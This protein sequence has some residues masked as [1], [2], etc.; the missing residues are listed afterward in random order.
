MIADQLSYTTGSF[1]Q[2]ISS[3]QPIVYKTRSIYPPVAPYP[4]ALVYTIFCLKKLY[5]VPGT[6]TVTSNPFFVISGIWLTRYV[7]FV[8][9]INYL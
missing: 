2:K 1:C 5:R 9:T 7:S 6:N 8:Y 3:R 4:R